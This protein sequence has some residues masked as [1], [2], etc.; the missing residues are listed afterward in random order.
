MPAF[1]FS[2]NINVGDV[3]QTSWANSVSA[4]LN[5]IGPLI[6]DV[7]VFYGTS[8]PTAARYIWFKDAGNGIIELW[9]ED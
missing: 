7:P 2:T 4:A 3:G 5:Q 8:T 6:G 1:N 9:V